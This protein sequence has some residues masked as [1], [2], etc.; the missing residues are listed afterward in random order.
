MH[1]HPRSQRL[2]CSSLYLALVIA[3]I[4]PAF[5]Q[6]GGDQT[7][8]LEQVKQLR[9]QQAQL[10]QM[11]RDNETAL[12][13]IEARL[14]VA[15]TTTETPP[16]VTAASPAAT[17]AVS[18][19]TA[20]PI[21]ATGPALA[22]R[23]N[24][25][26]DLRV[27]SQFDNSN[28]I[29]ADRG[30][31]QVR[32]RLA[33]TFA[34]NDHISLGA[35]L[36]TG[37]PDNPR[38]SDV[39]MSNWDNDFEV[40]LDQAYLQLAFGDLKIHGGKIPQPFVR[41][42]LV[43]DGDVNPQGVSATWKH[44]LG[45]G[46]ALRANSLFFIIDERATGANSTL[47]GVQLGYDTPRLG[48]WKFDASAAHYDYTLGSM[49]GGN[50]ND[51][52]SNLRN[53]DG[54]YLSG[55]RLVDVIVGASYQGLG[56]RW[57]LR[58]VGDYVHNTAAKVDADSGYSAD[59]TL[60]RSSQVGDWRFSYGHAMAENDAVLTAFSTDNIGLASNY[61][62]H[63]LGVDYMVWPK[64]TLSAVWFRYRPLSARYAGSNDPD[65]WINR[66]R[67]ALMVGF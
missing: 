48:D 64:T 57:P 31:G 21:A 36:V 53:P 45:N 5:A 33:A 3:G 12:R 67:I 19:T 54:S 51:W 23:L 39:Q 14:G 44:A 41:T 30:S 18:T 20:T 56:E 61:R 55:Y 50:A 34:V 1:A 42:E 66:F 28:P 16:V 22:P 46:A 10:A 11:Q 52:R 35:R 27:R 4:A 6:D 25:S 59:V 60:G 32:A 17:P 63:S 58:I 29:A 37:D 15:T 13:L 8:L 7:A 24:I 38:S 26:G 9:A 2:R 47:R 62:M 40:S 43:W 65:D 49:A